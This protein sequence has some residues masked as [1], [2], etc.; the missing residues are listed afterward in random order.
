M[1]YTVGV[2]GVGEAVKSAVWVG[3]T[4][5]RL[6][7]VDGVEVVEIEGLSVC[8]GD[9]VGALSDRDGVPCSDIEPVAEGLG[10][11]LWVRL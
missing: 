6:G 10:V 3:E 4:V 1:I 9:G 2:G 11:R 7:L 8:V 5:A